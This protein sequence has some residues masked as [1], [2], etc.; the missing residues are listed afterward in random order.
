VARRF[1]ALDRDGCIIV[2]RHYLADPLAIEL[3]PGAAAGLRHMRSVGLGVIVLT[4]QSAVGR[5]FFDEAHLA[6][7]HHRLGDL[8]Q[9]EGVH[10]D[11]LYY[12]PHT[13][14]EQ[15]R[16]RKPQP[17]LLER[18]AREFG[19]ALQESSVVGDKACDIE[20]GRR[21]GATTF[22]VRTGYGAQVAAEG[23]ATPDHLVDSLWD[24][25]QVMERL[26]AADR[27][28]VTDAAQQ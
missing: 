21:M 23:M 9:V 22:L 11:G 13:P 20:L 25:A 19:F 1:V 4:N 27:K 6:R 26:M 17:G 12:C 15:C 24:A 3:L 7:I 5:G 8:L 14:D 2:E 10:L 28:V 18:A 16:C